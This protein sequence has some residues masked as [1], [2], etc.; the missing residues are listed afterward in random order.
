MVIVDA[1]IR[2][3][4]HNSFAARKPNKKREAIAKARR[5]MQ[6]VACLKQAVRVNSSQELV[7]I[8]SIRELAIHKMC[9]ED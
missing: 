1:V 9:S 5:A 3:I 4:G 7:F 6:R 2:V 8:E